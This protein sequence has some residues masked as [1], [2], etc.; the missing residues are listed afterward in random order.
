MNFRLSFLLFLCVFFVK[1][2]AAQ[3]V[4]APWII[5]PVMNIDDKFEFSLPEDADY[6]VV[7]K[8]KKS[9]LFD[10]TGKTI[11][12]IEYEEITLIPCGWI[13]ATK[14]GKRLLYNAKL[15]CMS[16]PYDQ[17]KVYNNGT[18]LV[19]KGKLCGIINMKGEELVPVKY[20]RTIQMTELDG[21]TFTFVGPDEK[22]EFEMPHGYVLPSK[23]SAEDAKA[24]SVVAG[25][26]RIMNRLHYSMGLLNMNRDTVVPPIYRFIDVHPAGYIAATF[27]DKTYGVIDVH[28]KTLYPF[29]ADRIGKWTKSG[30][31]PVRFEKKWGL[32]RFPKGEIV[33]P[34]GEFEYI[35]MYDPEKDLFI[36]TKDNLRGVIDLKKKTIVPC[37]YKYISE[38]DQ[39]TT[40]LITEQE[41]FG[42]W[43]RPTNF[44]HAPEFKTI[45]HLN[46]SLIIVTVDSLKGVMDAKTGKYVIPLSEYQIESIGNYF[47]S[48][49]PLDWRARTTHE[50]HIHGLYDRQGN[51]VIPHDTAA[52]VIVPK[53]NTFW[54]CYEEEDSSR[55]WEQR[56]LHGKILQTMPKKGADLKKA[57]YFP[58]LYRFGN[59]VTTARKITYTD[60]QGQ[61]RL[62]QFISDQF[63]ENLRR[64][65]LNDRWGC[66][67]E[68]GKIVIQPVFEQ[69][70]TSQ[71]GYIRVKYQGKWG[72]LKNPRFDYFADLEKMIKK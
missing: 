42:F 40:R 47:D 41:K 64:V 51:L 12:P 69:L 62:Y 9:G 39:I 59:G 14:E 72:I 11:L 33:F 25:Y 36:I 10:K 19:D 35:E 7:T 63:Y 17:F 55:V 8:N 22:R 48:H 67:D 44:I 27:D 43:F 70:E 56:D 65:K 53:E 68:E 4:G 20:T 5:P 2:T 49:K 32:L 26:Y 15:E 24:R 16:L 18:A 66:V 21:T 52:I 13:T 60:A 38:Y 45:S 34:F 1:T 71:K 28:H 29:T 30:L 54:I 6:F 57:G 23:K 37:A 58:T 46:D 3:E 31:I 50:R 61:E